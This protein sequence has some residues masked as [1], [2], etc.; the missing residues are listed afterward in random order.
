MSSVTTARAAFH[1][2]VS[3]SSRKQEYALHLWAWLFACCLSFFYLFIFYYFLSIDACACLLWELLGFCGISCRLLTLLYK[4]PWEN[5]SVW[6]GAVRLSRIRVYLPGWLIQIY[7][8]HVTGWK[9]NWNWPSM[10]DLF[11]NI[12]CTNLTLWRAHLLLLMATDWN[13]VCYFFLFVV[14]VLMECSLLS[15]LSK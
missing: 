13:Q 12:L 11:R 4:F 14:V 2:H 8:R 9:S 3:S 6:F 5:G 10:L 1:R 7:C 15:Q